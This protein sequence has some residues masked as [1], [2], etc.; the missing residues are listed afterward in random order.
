M[1]L[2]GSFKLFLQKDFALTKKANTRHKPKATN[3]A[4]KNFSEDEN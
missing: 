4:H 3:K 1:K 2:L